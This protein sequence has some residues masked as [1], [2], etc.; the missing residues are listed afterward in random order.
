[1][2]AWGEMASAEVWQTL[3][4]PGF[5]PGDQGDGTWLTALPDGRGLRQPIRV[6]PG[7][8]DRGIASL[9]VT[10]ASFS[11]LDAL[12]DALAD[13]VRGLDAEVIVGLPTLGLP[14]A[15]GLARRLG[16]ARYVALGTSR[17]FWYDARLSEPLRSITSPDTDKRLW[18]DPRTV[19][20]CGGRRVLLVDD[21][22]STGASMGAALRLM[23]RVGIR[24]VGLACCMAQGHAGRD[25]RQTLA[26][27]A[28]FAYAIE[29][30]LLELDG[31][32]WIPRR[33]EG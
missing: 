29:T 7:T 11:V 21:V 30:P 1:M 8:T 32:T 15:E 33:A 17:K 27:D 3:L 10:Q 25:V 22:V 31:G 13:R 16:H 20:W 2:P 24:P 9:I 4:A 28:A 12:L 5:A 23:R 26:P 19:A 18:I 14:V 6:L